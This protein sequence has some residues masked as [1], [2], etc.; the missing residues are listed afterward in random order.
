MIDLF[1]GKAAIEVLKTFMASKKQAEEDRK[2]DANKRLAIYHDDWDDILEEELADQF[3]RVNYNNIHLCKNTTQNILKKVINDISLVYKQAPERSIKD[4]NY[5]AID[6]DSTMQLANRYL[7]LLNEVLIRPVWDENKKNVKLMILTPANTSVVQNEEDPTQADGIYYEL[8]AGDDPL[9]TETK[10]Y[11]FFSRDEHFVFTDKG[12]IRPAVDNEEMLNPYKKDGVGVL[13]FVILH[14][15]N[16]P[17]MFWDPTDGNDLV[18]GTIITG[19]KRTMKD[20]AFKNQSFKQIWMRSKDEVPPAKLVI[21]PLTMLQVHGES[22]EIGIIDLQ[23]D[24]AAMDNTLQGDINAFLATYGL[25]VDM[26]AVS[27]KELSGKALEVMNRALKE[28]RETQTKLFR[29]AEEEL[30]DLIRIVYEHHAGKGM[31]E[32]DFSINFIE[33]EIYT[34]PGELKKQAWWDMTHGLMSPGDYYLKFNPDGAESEEEAESIMTENMRKLK[35]MQ[36]QGFTLESLF[37]DSRTN[38]DAIGQ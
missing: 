31:A 15:N 27:P 13:P 28:I 21:D 22:D 7:N 3:E 20:Y 12:D 38:T 26:F 35:E 6:I 33:P 1:E 18:D 24:F 5:N 17:G 8:E 23:A 2:A 36:S 34:D 9:S 16:R 19:M 10:F 11:V 32:E 25:T 30:Y 4:E 37:G 14:K 29:K